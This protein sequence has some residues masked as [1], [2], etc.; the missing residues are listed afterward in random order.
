MRSA[1]SPKPLEVYLLGVVDFLAMQAFQRRLVY[2][3]EEREGGVLVLCEHPPTITVGR[4]GSRADILPD[5]QELDE[6]RIRVHWVARGGGSVFHIPGQLV[7]YLVLPLSPLGISVRQYLRSLDHLVIAVLREFGLTGRPTPEL[8]GVLLGGARVATVGV[9]V[10]RWITTHG[11]TLNVGP[12]LAPLRSVREGNRV[13]GYLPQTSMEARRQR[14]T[15]MA[16]VRETMI[17]QVER[18]FGLEQAHLYTDHPM[19]HVLNPRS[20][21]H[22]LLRG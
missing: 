7:A 5:D 9:G 22:A 8:G 11:F 3:A 6:A 21:V 18:R 15:P 1:T 14:P 4:A 17:R 12:Y 20:A 10:H 13:G 2:E 19:F 16:K